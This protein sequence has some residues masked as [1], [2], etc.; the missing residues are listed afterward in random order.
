[1]AGRFL[2]TQ[3]LGDGGANWNQLA[4]D[5]SAQSKF[6][7][8]RCPWCGTEMGPKPKPRRGQDLI[9]YERVGKK[10]EFR[11]LDNACRFGGRR[12]LPIHV[13]DEDIYDSR[14]SIVIGTVD[15]F[16]M[17]AW[18][19]DARSLFGLD[20]DGN[21]RYSP[22]GLIVQDELHL[23]SGPLGSMVGL[24]E[25][26]IDDLCTDRRESPSC[27]PKIIASTATIRRYE[28]QILSLFGRDRVALFPPQ[29]LEE[30]RSFFAEPATDAEGNLSLVGVTSE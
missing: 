29:G 26:V 28:D 2:D 21:R 23:I 6:L 25:S 30:G 15:K 12:K 1:M 17:L 4:S 19:P 9:G 18:R 13:V 24:Y 3:L 10:I 14:P 11:C 20:D 8:L 22:P 5:P 27:S 16:A 7:L